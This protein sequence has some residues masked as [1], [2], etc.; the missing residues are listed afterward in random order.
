MLG[1]TG[2]YL[3]ATYVKNK[4]STSPIKMNVIIF[5]LSIPNRPMFLL[6]ENDNTVNTKNK[7]KNIINII[8]IAVILT[9]MLC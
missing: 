9:H 1:K 5:S 4:Y 7:D 2:I 3:S 6:Q 8:D